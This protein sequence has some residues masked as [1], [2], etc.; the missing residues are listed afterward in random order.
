M[1]KAAIQT[2]AP[3]E[4]SAIQQDTTTGYY[5]YA[6]G[7]MPQ[8]V[9]ILCPAAMVELGF[10]QYLGFEDNPSGG[11]FQDQDTS[12]DIPTKVGLPLSVRHN[13]PVFEMDNKIGTYQFADSKNM[14]AKWLS[15]KVDFNNENSGRKQI[16]NGNVFVLRKDGGHLLPQHLEALVE[17]CIG[18]HK[19]ILE[20]AN[21]LKEQEKLYARQTRP[22]A[23]QSFFDRYR[24]KNYAD[25][26][27]WAQLPSP[28]D[29]A[30]L[31]GNGSQRVNHDLGFMSPYEA[32]ATTL[33]D[34]LSPPGSIIPMTRKQGGHGLIACRYKD[35]GNSETLRLGQMI[36]PV[37]IMVPP[38]PFNAGRRPFEKSEN[39]KRKAALEVRITPSRDL[40]GEP[41]NKNEQWTIPSH[42]DGS[43]HRR[44]RLETGDQDKGIVEECVRQ[45][46]EE[47]VFELR[48]N[49]TRCAQYL[50]EQIIRQP[51][52]SSLARRRDMQDS[53]SSIGIASSSGTSKTQSPI[54]SDVPCTPA[55][56][57][58]ARKEFIEEFTTEPPVMILNL[59]PSENALEKLP[60]YYVKFFADDN[61]NSTAHSFSE[62]EPQAIPARGLFARE[63]GSALPMAT[64]SLEQLEHTSSDLPDSSSLQQQAIEVSR[65]DVEW[66][67]QH[68]ARHSRDGAK[69]QLE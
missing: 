10:S 46:V 28:Y 32:P 30:T 26:L 50:A 56:G 65:A 22:A 2:S 44:K 12:Y 63:K 40:T 16:F 9:V 7:N 1:Q 68:D 35:A 47:N 21:N 11:M 55:K 45:N 43:E 31:G 48:R 34:V 24:K 60:E 66:L 15:V 27:V 3:S 23:F 18:F 54:E 62:K 61:K 39:A 64:I 37:A 53:D 20:R 57:V 67:S 6:V 25:D 51:R 17:F 29:R 58:T 4:L 41:G 49:E 5:P 36:A 19:E 33:Q 13:D 52:L 59:L 14:V 69:E 8:G 38:A 42:N